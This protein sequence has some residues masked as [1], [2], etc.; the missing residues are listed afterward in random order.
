MIIA[1]GIRW[2]E[3]QEAAEDRKS[4]WIRATA[5]LTPDKPGTRII[6]YETEIDFSALT[7]LV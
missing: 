3:V 2:D 1:V 7:L 4:W 6:V 5:S